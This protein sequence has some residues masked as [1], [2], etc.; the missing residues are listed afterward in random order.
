MKCNKGIRLLSGCRASIAVAA[1]PLNPTNHPR[2]HSSVIVRIKS[3][4]LRLLLLRFLTRLT[5]INRSFLPF[6]ALPTKM[7]SRRK[8]T[9]N[10]YLLPRILGGIR[11]PIRRNLPRRLPTK[12]ERMS[13]RLPLHWN[14]WVLFVVTSIKT[15]FRNLRVFPM[16]RWL[17]KASNYSVFPSCP[18]STRRRRFLTRNGRIMKR[19][20]VVK[21]I[22]RT[23]LVR[24]DIFVR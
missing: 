7:T 13:E 23:P 12:Q 15:T 20:F 9:R 11:I 14:P 3:N 18:S 21:R 4:L 8:T 24:K 17:V 2:M 1:T 5:T 22:A 6:C 10:T 19:S 16:R